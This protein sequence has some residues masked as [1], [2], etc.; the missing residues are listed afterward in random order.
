M[1]EH[2]IAVGAT[3]LLAELRRLRPLQAAAITAEC[4]TEGTPAHAAARARARRI[5]S[6]FDALVERAWAA[7][8]SDDPF[9]DIA[10]R[11]E[12]AAAWAE[13]TQSGVLHGLVDPA[14][15]DDQPCWRDRAWAELLVACERACGTRI[16]PRY[17]DKDQ[18]GARHG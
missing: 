1:A 18:E 3:D 14:Q 16:E 8:P 10:V 7:G 9:A 2:S 11:A 6:K 12:I 5:E 17:I 15:P 13:Y 4:D